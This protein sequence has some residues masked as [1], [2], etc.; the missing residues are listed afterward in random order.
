MYKIFFHEKVK[1][2]LKDLPVSHLVVIKTAINERLSQHPY[3]FKALSGKRF[4]GLY[5]LRVADYRVVYCVDDDIVRI[6]AIGH[7]S[8]IYKFLD[9]RVTV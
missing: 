3:D 6:L 5:R 8:E 7:R 4:R 9:K 2:D 1:K